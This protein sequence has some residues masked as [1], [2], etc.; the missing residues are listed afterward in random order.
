[1]DLGQPLVIAFGDGVGFEKRQGDA[2]HAEGRQQ[3]RAGLAAPK[4][5]ATGERDGIATSSTP[6]PASRTPAD[7]PPGERERLGIA[8]Y[9]YHTEQVPAW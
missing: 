4:L 5:L 1:M 9:G 3:P 2:G 6:G 8:V 7:E